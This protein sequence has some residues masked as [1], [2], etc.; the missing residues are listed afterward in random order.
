MK[1]KAQ[2]NLDY[3]ARPKKAKSVSRFKRAYNRRTSATLGRI[4]GK[5]AP[6]NTTLARAP[7]PFT[8]KK[9]VTFL[10]ENALTQMGGASNVVTSII[11]CN[12]AFDFDSSGDYG[13]KQPLFYDVLMSASGPYKTYKVL[14]WKTTYTFINNNANT[15]VDI[16]VS[17]PVAATAEIDSLAEMDNFPGVKRL[18]LTTQGGSKNMGTV[19]VTGNLSDVYDHSK[20]DANFTGSYNGSPTSVVYQ[21]ALARG[22]DGSTAPAVYVSIKHE[23][24]T[25]LNYLD[26]IVS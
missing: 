11:K 14:S 23:A 5:V 22:S 10:Y 17:P 8:G 6:S 13:N 1:R 3:Y 21:V 7:G 16:F 19:V 25:E 2:S 24:Y 4:T 9:F 12:D 20:N 26:A 15:P 18:Y